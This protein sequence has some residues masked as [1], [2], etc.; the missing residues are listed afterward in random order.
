MHIAKSIFDTFL[1]DFIFKPSI[2]SYYQQYECQ[3]NQIENLN[4]K[5]DFRSY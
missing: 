3:G 5:V 2:F 4:T 1:T